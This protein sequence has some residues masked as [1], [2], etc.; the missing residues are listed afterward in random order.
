M[1]PLKKRHAGSYMSLQN[2]GSS[3]QFIS[4]G[5][6]TGIDRKFAVNDRQM[7]QVVSIVTGP[8]QMGS[9]TVMMPLQHTMGM[10]SVGSLISTT[11]SQSGFSASSSQASGLNVQSGRYFY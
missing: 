3:S 4:V 6:N 7:Q 5:D 11:S 10:S 2:V 9:A 1:F 8:Q